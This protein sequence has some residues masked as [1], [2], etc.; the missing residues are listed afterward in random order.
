MTPFIGT[1]VIC[2]TGFWVAFECK[3][4]WL[5]VGMLALMSMAVVAKFIEMMETT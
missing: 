2:C 5:F 1:M 4:H 3:K